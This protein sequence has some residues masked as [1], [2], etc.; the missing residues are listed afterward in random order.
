MKPA[1]I[2]NWPLLGGRF[3]IFLLYLAVTRWHPAVAHEWVKWVLIF[4]LGMFYQFVADAFYRRAYKNRVDASFD[5]IVQD[6]QNVTTLSDKVDKTVLW[7]ILEV[8][9][10]DLADTDVPFD[11]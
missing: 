4:V 2:I 6:V 10:G 3:V 5:A 9:H 1:F 8:R 7:G 11:F